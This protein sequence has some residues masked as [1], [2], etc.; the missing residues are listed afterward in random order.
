M[1]IGYAH[2]KLLVAV[3]GSVL[4]DLPLGVQPHVADRR[5]R[6]RSPEA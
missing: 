4:V 3:M 5:L 2:E 6:S 1:P